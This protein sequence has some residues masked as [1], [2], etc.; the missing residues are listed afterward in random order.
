VRVSSSSQDLASQSDAISQAARARGDRLERWFREK[1]SG[2]TLER[3]VLKEVRAAVRRGELRKLYVFRIDRLTRSGIRDT[4]ALLEELER[5]GC[6]VVTVAD[7]FDLEGPTRELV[8][9]MIAWGAQMERIAL[10]ERISAAR[11]RVEKAG[12][13]WGRPRRV[14]DI[15]RARKLEREGKTRRQIAAALKI[16]RSTLSDVLSAR[17]NERARTAS[18]LSDIVAP[19][20]RFRTCIKRPRS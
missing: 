18:V 11:A 17:R 7:G 16:P 20:T 19:A 5:G 1:V 3:P 15:A 4:L 14:F 9:A 12:G 10:G 8:L 2:R 13:R 6:K